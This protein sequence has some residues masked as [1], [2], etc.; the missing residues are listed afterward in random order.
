M[1]TLPRLNTERKLLAHMR[2]ELR[3]VTHTITVG[4]YADLLA[5][6]DACVAIADLLARSIDT[7][8]TDADTIAQLTLA[9]ALEAA[10]EAF[11]DNLACHT[12]EACPA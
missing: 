8:T 6:H 11:G 4:V 2:A 1:Q 7:A 9:A 12:W 10:V 5:S 3:A